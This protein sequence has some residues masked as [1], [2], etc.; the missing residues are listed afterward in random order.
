MLLLVWYSDVG[1]VL[2]FEIFDDVNFLVLVELC[3]IFNVLVEYLLVGIGDILVKWYE[4]VVLVLQ[5]MVLLF[6]VWLGINGVLVICDVLLV[7][8]EMVLV[9]QCCGDLIQ[10]FCDVVEVIIVGGGMVGGL[11]ECYIWVVVV[12]VVYNGLMVLLQMDKFFYGIKVVYGI[13][14]Q[15][16]LFGQDDVLVQLVQ[17]YQCFNLLIILVVLEVDINN[18]VELD[19]VIVYILCLGEL[20]YYLL[21]ML[22]F[23]VLCVVFE[24]V[25]YFSC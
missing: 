20:I 9:D 13:L 6:I 15:S 11:G 16:V 2:N 22:I 7:S 1:Q 24:K 23:E 19:W 17:V 12:Y 21:V 3:I 8:S 18:C 25:E 10:V 14:V 5:L 4:V